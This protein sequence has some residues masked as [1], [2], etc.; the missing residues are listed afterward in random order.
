MSHVVAKSRRPQLRSVT[1]VCSHVIDPAHGRAG[2]AARAHHRP[3]RLV[4]Q[5]ARDIATD[6]TVRAGHQP[7]VRW[8]C[9]GPSVAA[10]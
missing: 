3:V 4:P 9:H 10:H 8:T 2:A 5:V 7:D 1:E 6:E